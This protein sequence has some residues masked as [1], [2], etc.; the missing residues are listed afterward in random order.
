M[1]VELQWFDQG[2]RKE[3]GNMDYSLEDW[4][5]NIRIY[6]VTC[7]V[8]ASLALYQIVPIQSCRILTRQEA[9]LMLRI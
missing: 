9:D 4:L 6:D 2:L 5:P 3:L 7:Y 1:C 8:S